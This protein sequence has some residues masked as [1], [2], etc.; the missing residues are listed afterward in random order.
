MENISSMRKYGAEMF[1]TFLLVSMSV[2]TAMFAGAFMDGYTSVIA[3]AMA[4]GLSLMIAAYTIGPISG[5]HINPAVSLAM[6][7]NKKL[8]GRDLLGYILA[9]I[10]GAIL[11]ALLV[12]TIAAPLLGTG[13][14]WLGANHYEGLREISGAN[15]GVAIVMAMLLEIVL[16]F[17]FVFAILAV[18]RK[19]EM[20]KYAPVLIAAALVL[21]HLVGI[22]VTGTSVNPARSIGSAIFSGAA[23]IRQVWL[24]IIAPL[25]G[26]VGAAFF[27]RLMFKDEQ[28][29]LGVE[30]TPKAD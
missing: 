11:G 12:F 4:F 30:P 27:A 23:G 7:I 22:P 15:M 25:V 16:T 17:V 18:T 5:C 13:N 24:F 28:K 1:G 14:L 10:I 21:V 9:Q 8:S 3:I 20:K 6:F 19:E 29:S 26:A 2:G